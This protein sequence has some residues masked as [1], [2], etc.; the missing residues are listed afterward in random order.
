M[1]LSTKG[2]YG[3][4][5]MVDLAVN[6][7]NDAPVSLNSIA[8]RQNISENYL[9]QIIAMMRKAGL[10]ISQRGAG[11]GYFISKPLDEISAADILRA[12]E[13]D[14][15]IVDCPGLSDFNNDTE[16]ECEASHLCVTKYVWDRVNIAINTTLDSISLNELTAES[17]KILEKNWN[18]PT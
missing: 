8:K 6:S 3:L 17:K 13:G 16:K 2:I 18:T 4:R 1:K 12:L 9:E 7:N 15:C 11:G 10:V 14:L 5:A